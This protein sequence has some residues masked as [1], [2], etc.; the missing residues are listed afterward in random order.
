SS[1]SR[2]SAR[3]VRTSWAT[4]SPLSLSAVVLTHTAER[5]SGDRRR[6]LAVSALMTSSTVH[7]SPATAAFSAGRSGWGL[8][9]SGGSARPGERD[10]SATTAKYARR[11]MNRSPV[12][13]EG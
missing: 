11:F 9:L 12:K 7:L 6:L 4:R 1:T 13:G 8:G 3:F 5:P 2:F 10:T